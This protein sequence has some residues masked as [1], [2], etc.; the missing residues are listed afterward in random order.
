M[1]IIP[2]AKGVGLVDNLTAD[3]QQQL[4]GKQPVGSY[5]TT[6]DVGTTVQAYDT[7]LAAWAGVATADKQDTLV[8][9]TNIKTVNGESVLGAGNI[10]IAASSPTL[11]I[12]NKTA[13]Y[14]VVAGDL[15]KIIN[16]TSGSFT[17]SLTAAAT[18]GAGFNVTVWNTNDGVIT[19]DPSG[20]ETIDGGYTTLLLRNGEGVQ[21]ICNGVGWQT[22]SQKEL[23]T[24]SEN[25]TNASTRPVASGSG[26]VAISYGCTASGVV[27]FSAG[28]NSS[29]NG[30]QATATAAM[31]LGGSYASGTDSFAAAI[32]NNTSSYGATGANSVAI[33]QFA[34]A[35]GS[36][37]MALH[38]YS[39]ASSMRALAVMG[40]AAT[41]VNSI[42]VGE[43][44]SA[45]HAR[46]IALQ[47]GNSRYIGHFV[48]A[49]YNP[50]AQKGMGCLYAL[51]ADSTPTK[52]TTDSLVVGT[53]NQVILPNNSTYAFTGTIVAQQSKAQGSAT[54]A[55]KVEG[56]ITRG[57]NAA[58]TTL[59]A[60]T[61]TAISNAP[62]WTLALS[63]DTTN[64]GL[65]VTFTGA[66]ATNIRTVA[67][68]ETVEVTYA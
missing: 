2:I 3:A 41:G 50:I 65:A 46:S 8:S 68:I 11:T 45:N 5:L 28:V 40:A 47:N 16:C 57:A 61:V 19:L 39:Q 1:S 59:V 26:A 29:G 22:G 31:A 60:S 51:T 4:D 12:N 35:A 23:R 17:V 36:S 67:T 25:M 66:A 21:L 63:A 32:A 37:S 9:G 27:A 14:T 64:G 49:P 30:S 15:G 18:L 48:I 13:A 58:A 44:S 20:S 34:K 53:A 55:W 7:D 24:Y 10:A 54:A 38:Y 33:G 42:A 56:L 6:S 52:L 62:A 43:N